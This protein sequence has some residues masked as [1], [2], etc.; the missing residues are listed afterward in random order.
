MVDNLAAEYSVRELCGIY[1]VSR[2]GYEEWKA[3]QESEAEDTDGRLIV[4]I[5]AIH[6]K[7][8]YSYGTPKITVVLKKKGY[9]V[10]HKRVARLMREHNIRGRKRAS[11]RPRTTDSRHNLPVAPNRRWSR[12]LC[13]GRVLRFVA[14]VEHLQN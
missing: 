4:E 9:E 7:S 13:H 2:H 11:Y 6:K 12:S 5:K 3:R 10:N 1:G 14:L 8:R